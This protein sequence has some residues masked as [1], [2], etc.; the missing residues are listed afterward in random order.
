MVP[1]RILPLQALAVHSRTLARAL[2]YA[3]LVVLHVV[4]DNALEQLRYHLL[5]RR[6]RVKGRDVQLV[7]VAFQRELRVHLAIVVPRLEHV[8]VALD[9]AARGLLLVVQRGDLV[10]DVRDGDRH[11][12]SMCR[13]HRDL[14][15]VR[16]SLDFVRQ[17]LT[18]D[19]ATALARAWSRAPCS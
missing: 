6:P 14:R 8:L 19:A 3:V 12:V 15:L 9:H 2:A 10:V 5:V 4:V 11:G 7:V 18:T 17:D 1:D 13:L 16:R